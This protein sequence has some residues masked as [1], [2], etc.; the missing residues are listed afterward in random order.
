MGKTVEQLEELLKKGPVKFK[1]T[2]VNGEE[3]EAYG[4]KNL[5]IVKEEYGE[6]ML[7][8]GTGI[9]TNDNVIRYFDLNSEGWRSFRKECFLDYTEK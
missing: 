4:T 1:Y 3:R 5:D 9:E 2:K 7:P 8:K 6:Q